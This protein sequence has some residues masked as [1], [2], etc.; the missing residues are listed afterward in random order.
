MQERNCITNHLLLRTL[1]A[2]RVRVCARGGCGV[3][4]VFEHSCIS[5]RSIL[6]QL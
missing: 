5:K 4:S 6:H 1:A 2:A 3:Q